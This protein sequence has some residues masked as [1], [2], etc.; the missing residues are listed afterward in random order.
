MRHFC[1]SLVLV[2]GTAV[3]AFADTNNDK[4]DHDYPTVARVE[5]VQE[6]IEKK[7]GVVANLYKCSCAIDWIARKLTYDE[8]VEAQTYSKYA[9][10][11]GEG[12]GIF[13]DSPEAKEKAKLYRQ[14]EADAFKGCGL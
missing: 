9:T 2:C 6:C 5:Y 3:P 11:P 4:S 1:I 10:L 14:L 7:G 8:F 12:G 13:R